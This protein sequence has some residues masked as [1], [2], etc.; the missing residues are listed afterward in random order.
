ML[1]A[2]CILSG[3]SDPGCPDLQALVALGAKPAQEE[4]P[5]L[6]LMAHHPLLQTTEHVDE[7]ATLEMQRS[8]VR[9]ARA[10]TLG[11]LQQRWHSTATELKV[12]LGGCLLLCPV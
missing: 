7:H 11:R 10:A 4:V 5:L 8:A 12:R 1:R 2:L 9:K 3:V 6:L